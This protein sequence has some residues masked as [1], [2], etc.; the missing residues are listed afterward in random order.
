[1]YMLAVCAVCAMAHF[2]P[3]EALAILLPSSAK[4]LLVLVY[5]MRADMLSSHPNQVHTSHPVVLDS[6]ALDNAL[7]LPI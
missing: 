1:M 2:G 7:I 3:V 4:S 5:C 6:P